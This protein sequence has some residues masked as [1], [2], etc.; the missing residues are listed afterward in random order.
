MQRH[1]NKIFQLCVYGLIVEQRG[2]SQRVTLAESPK[3]EQTQKACNFGALENHYFEQTA[4]NFNLL[5]E[6]MPKCCQNYF[7]F[8]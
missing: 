8:E 3:S 7:H 5:L 4:H 6:A 1:I 2:H